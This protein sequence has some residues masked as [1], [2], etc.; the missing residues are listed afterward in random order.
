MYI[1]NV[2]DYD[3]LTLCNC[4]NNDNN[5]EIVI[6]LL[7]TIPCGM[8]LICLISLMVNS[9][10]KP[11]LSKNSYLLDTNGEVF[12]PK[13]SCSLYHHR[14]I[15]MRKKLFLNKFQFKYY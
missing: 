3:N 10:V 4:K 5:N 7:T 15:G 11:L 8:S 13:T 12:I 1:T 2:T 6:P 9:L 14:T